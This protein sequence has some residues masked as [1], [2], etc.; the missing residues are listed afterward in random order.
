MRLGA[1]GGRG[2]AARGGS[3]A[4]RGGSGAVGSAA[5]RK[6][7]HP[8]IDT[9]AA[10]AADRPD[11]GGLSE[12]S[13][14]SECGAE[15]NWQSLLARAAADCQPPE[16]EHNGSEARVDE[17]AVLPGASA[18][19][20]ALSR[21]SAST[22]QPDDDF[23]A[24]QSDAPS[25]HST[26]TPTRAAVLSQM[27]PV[28]RLL[29]SAVVL[30]PISTRRASVS[31]G[32]LDCA[33]QAA[34][35]FP[36][37][38]LLARADLASEQTA[39]L[40]T[41]SDLSPSLPPCLWTTLSAALDARLS[42]LSSAP[43]LRSSAVLCALLRC[44]AA[45]L[46]S[47]LSLLAVYGDV[48]GCVLPAVHRVTQRIHPLLLDASMPPVV[49]QHAAGLARCV[50]LTH[51]PV[52]VVDGMDPLLPAS[53]S[54]AS[55][56]S[57]PSSS[58]LSGFPA[59]ASESALYFPS[60]SA[61]DLRRLQESHPDLDGQL[62]RDSAHS[63]V[64]AL[65]EAVE[66]W[67]VVSASVCVHL[68]LLLFVVRQR[69]VC[70]AP[71]CV[72][73]LLRVAA[74]LSALPASSP[75]AS[76]LQTVRLG[77]FSLFRLSSCSA[78]WAGM[79]A[80]L[81]QPANSILAME[82]QRLHKQRS[83]SASH[84]QLVEA[85]QQQQQTQ[86]AQPA[87]GQAAEPSSF[88]S[89]DGASSAMRAVLDV[90]SS[91]VQPLL[92]AALSLP[93]P[94][95]CDLIMRSLHALPLP[96]SS[97][98]H[99]G[100]SQQQQQTLIQV[101]AATRQVQWKAADAAL[102]HSADHKPLTGST[103]APP[104]AAAASD[105]GSSRSTVP[106]LATQPLS[107]PAQSS[108]SRLC[109]VRI[110]SA[111]VEQAASQ[112]SMTALRAA[113]LPSITLA[114]A[115][116]AVEHSVEVTD[117]ELLLHWAAEQQHSAYQQ[118]HGDAEEEEE[119]DSRAEEEDEEEE[120]DGVVSTRS[121]LSSLR[122]SSSLCGSSDYSALLSY[123]LSDVVERYELALTFSYQLAR[124][125]PA[126]I[127]LTAAHGD[128]DTQAVHADVHM[129]ET[130]E[131]QL[132]T[133]QQPGSVEQQPAD[134]GAARGDGVRGKRRLAV[135][136]S[137]P[138]EPA[139]KQQRTADNDS[140]ATAELE[141][142]QSALDGEA[143]AAASVAADLSPPTTVSPLL[144]D[145]SGAVLR[146]ARFLSALSSF[147]RAHGGIEYQQLVDGLLTALDSALSSSSA[148]DPPGAASMDSSPACAALVRL[149]LDLPLLPPSVWSLVARYLHSPTASSVGL[150]L[151][152]VL[153][154]QRPPASTRAMCLLLRCA[155]TGQSDSLRQACVV[156]AV[157]CIATP[158]A[159]ARL[160]SLV[161][162]RGLGLAA[163]VAE[164]SFLAQLPSIAVSIVVPP[165]PTYEDIQPL[166]IAAPPSSDT[167]AAV[168][169]SGSGGGSGGLWASAD[170]AHSGAA[171]GAG[172]SLSSLLSAV[173]SGDTSDG[174]EAEDETRRRAIQQL[175]ADGAR[176]KREFDKLVLRRQ[177]LVKEKEVRER[178]A[179]ERRQQRRQATR[180]HL[181]LLFALLQAWPRLASHCSSD[182]AAQLLERLWQVY[183]AASASEPARQLIH[184]FLPS[185]VQ[186]V[187]PALPLLVS[188]QS[189]PA[190][191]D[192]AVLHALQLLCSA[193]ASAADSSAQQQLVASGSAGGREQ[194]SLVLPTS[195]VSVVCWYLYHTRRG[196]ARFIIPLLPMLRAEQ[197]RRCLHRIIAL[198][199]VHLKVALHRML[200]PQLSLAAKGNRLS[201]P[202][203]QPLSPA[204][205][206]IALHRIDQNRRAALSSSDASTASPQPPDENGTEAAALPVSL[207]LQS[208]LPAATDLSV[209]AASSSAATYPSDD[210]SWLR[211][212][213]AA[214]Q[215]CFTSV[216]LFPASTLA[217]VVSA[218]RADRP[219]SRLF[220][221]TCIQCVQLQP[222]LSSFVLSVVHALVRSER[223]MVSVGLL[224]EGVLKLASLCLPA[225]LELLL[226]LPDEGVARLFGALGPPQLLEA[227]QAADRAAGETAADKAAGRKVAKPL[228][229]TPL[230]MCQVA[231]ARAILQQPQR[232]RHVYAQFVLHSEPQ[233]QQHAA[234]TRTQPPGTPAATAPPP[235]TSA[236]HSAVPPAAG[237]R[238]QAWL[239]SQATVAQADS[240][241]YPSRPPGPPATVPGGV[242]AG[243]AA[244]MAAV[245]GLAPPFSHRPAAAHPLSHPPGYFQHG[246]PPFHRPF[247]GQ[248]QH[249]R[250]PFQYAPANSPPPMPST[251]AAPPPQP[252]GGGGWKSVR[253]P[254][255]GSAAQQQPQP[256]T[257]HTAH[258]AARQY[259]GR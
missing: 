175:I 113:L 101:Q 217:S 114:G 140:G 115:A 70:Y 62:M 42:E 69:S 196:D 17:E 239:A 133:A 88:A 89:V 168:E 50:L 214:V 16:D 66:Q 187:G 26:P 39:A 224:W 109:F 59:L 185:M 63:L 92:S 191:C 2:A 160:R 58:S 241:L 151:L 166:P 201:Q 24:A 227:V 13:A 234:L 18:L 230:Q 125:T 142:T 31:C 200:R 251:G 129:A 122:L 33:L 237:D 64:A 10:S 183:A 245:P 41:A 169:G 54:A 45:T 120:S 190:A 226:D 5:D 83:H 223:S 244:G 197:L 243:G 49:T 184:A 218:L 209:C 248:S 205:L 221:R 96:S 84:A 180:T 238:Q 177:L 153:I 85:R 60:L 94:L 67:R 44:C 19:S 119:A 98:Q 77:L 172:S 55:P 206:V 23:D 107:A 212:L 216:D 47:T 174:S 152:R 34:A 75:V 162:Q 203:P 72:P 189:Q 102:P 171:V 182:E 28:L 71:L 110:L 147:F 228:K 91:A 30:S 138:A 51:S 105:V 220:L 207:P 181:A 236:A 124:L 176:R 6:L 78:H 167:S 9:Q 132:V 139:A 82:A 80:V 130:S 210:G 12:W 22:E 65:T 258:S 158:A 61:F 159:P 53:L 27:W 134:S 118:Q 247:G 131:A 199:A 219:L 173:A 99:S 52:A 163:R 257:Q 229:H 8:R 202:Q 161:V 127:Q 25:H 11:D 106:P 222:S 146:S 90:E 155:A 143:A 111:S 249:G 195:A 38:L 95:V 204:E 116:G 14:Q 73:A 79:L 121:L 135:E 253:I 81:Q 150:L 104:Q 20:A 259:G 179:E 141:Q 1:D 137:P 68:Q 148:A 198:P 136:H 93:L 178:Q 103:T 240:K 36:A 154:E 15:T 97:A 235:A 86:S 194:P 74:R 246:P 225:S 48:A 37:P 46:P 43:S 255:A 231:V 56:S 87:Y 208:P 213:I 149:L 156:L 117:A 123:I 250:P 35:A 211:S 145:D 186:A 157:D 108:L 57:S 112:R 165:V 21:L 188:L 144:D 242:L 256:Q 170:S 192:P 232:V 76:A 164:Q 32:A 254:A 100:A 3:A 7:S 4:A 233:P 128:G 252:A 193:T 29:Y 40:P 126:S 215:L